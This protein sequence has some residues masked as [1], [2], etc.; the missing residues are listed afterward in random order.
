MS[1]VDK[2]EPWLS[3]HIITVF[4]SLCVSGFIGFSGIAWGFGTATVETEATLKRQIAVMDTRIT[5]YHINND[6]KLAMIAEDAK[7]TK[8]NLQKVIVAAAV[9]QA[10]Q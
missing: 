1:K 10:K 9:L 3:Q 5:E 2:V 4:V 6:Q 8:E 7:W